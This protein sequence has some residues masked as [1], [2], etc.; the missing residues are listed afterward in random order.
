MPNVQVKG[1]NRPMQF[2]D[3]M[4]LHDI[5]EFLRTKYAQQAANGEQPQDLARMQGEAQETQLSLSERMGQGIS[6]ALY[7]SGVISDRYGAQRIGD[8]LS[9]VGEMLPGVGDVTA[10]DDAGRA[11]EKGNYG[12]AALHAAGTLPV[13]GD[14]AI[15][16]GV[17]AKNADL[18]KLA[19][20][21]KL[22]A[23]D[24]GRDEIWKETGW[25]ND[26]GDWKFE[27]DD[28]QAQ[29]TEWG[30]KQEIPDRYKRLYPE[31]QHK[32][33][34][35][36][37][38]AGYIDQ[39]HLK[40]AY[41]DALAKGELREVPGE[42][43]SLQNIDG[44]NWM[45]IGRDVPELE[46]RSTAL[47][48]LQHGVQNIEGFQR[49][50]SPML[51]DAELSNTGTKGRKYTQ[52]AEVKELLSEG[53]SEKDIIDIYKGMPEL[54]DV[55]SILKDKELL[56]NSP[57]QLKNKG[58]FDA[59]Q[60][61]AGEAEAR[62]VQTRMNLTP[63]ER[64][65]RP[66]WQDLDVPED[67]LIY[68][69]GVDSNKELS[70]SLDNTLTSDADNVKKF[71]QEESKDFEDQIDYALIE[72]EKNPE[73]AN[74]V[75]NDIIDQGYQPKNQIAVAKIRK[76]KPEKP[77]NFASVDELKLGEK[78]RAQY[79]INAQ[80]IAFAQSALEDPNISELSKARI[81]KDLDMRVSAQEMLASGMPLSEIIKILN[82]N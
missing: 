77:S 19:K 32:N 67:E 47:H 71:T 80:E 18:G 16:A 76:L 20:A 81:Q 11:L 49:G 28:S 4:P 50:G 70:L 72:S 65:A 42:G 37:P 33:G 38:I 45:E 56:K 5:R 30:L 64:L 10:G 34:Y 68:R 7:D 3:S 54:D 82:P 1:I 22:E 2:P 13:I 26:R 6:N 14:M 29:L 41:G 74:Q 12:E 78:E 79:T 43:G 51:M 21:K 8:N 39:P 66:P 57:T 27:I 44:V 62:L 73:I 61:L 58:N 23:S 59:Y 24:I 31:Y 15:F 69:K 40:G 25:F 75:L 17:M 35:Q 46:R 53:L 36:G 63:E 48:E 60:R 55:K 52:A 9:M